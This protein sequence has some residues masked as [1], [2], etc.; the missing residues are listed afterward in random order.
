DALVDKLSI[1][2]SPDPYAVI[3]QEFDR[4][5]MAMGPRFS[6]SAQHCRQLL[7]QGLTRARS[8]VALVVYGN[9]PLLRK[10]LGKL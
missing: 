3:G 8:E 6:L 1:P 10:L 7:Y 5:V 4:V 2:E 9:E